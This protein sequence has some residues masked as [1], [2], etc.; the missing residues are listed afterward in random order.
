MIKESLYRAGCRNIELSQAAQLTLLTQSVG[1]AAAVVLTDT[2]MHS[3]D[4][5]AALPQMFN[6]SKHRWPATPETDN[7]LATLINTG[8]GE[9]WHTSVS[10]LML[11]S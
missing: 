5:Y 10:Y 8:Q 9:M 6:V 3:D 7:S 4:S 1:T 11:S 2:P